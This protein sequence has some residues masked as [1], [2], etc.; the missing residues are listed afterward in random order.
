MPRRNISPKL[1][2]RQIPHRTII[3]NM[4]AGLRITDAFHHRRRDIIRRD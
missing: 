3:M 4:D 1:R 2:A